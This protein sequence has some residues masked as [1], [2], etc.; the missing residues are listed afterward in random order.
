MEVLGPRVQTTAKE[1]DDLKIEVPFLHV[2]GEG[3]RSEDET[4][5]RTFRLV[6]DPR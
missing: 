4:P 6:T 3:P 2:E 5:R 1:K